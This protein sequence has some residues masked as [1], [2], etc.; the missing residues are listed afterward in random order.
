MMRPAWWRR[1]LNT[2][3]FFKG[4]SCGQCPP[5]RMGTINLAALMTKIEQGEGTQKDMESL[6]AALWIC[7]GDGLL[8]AGDRC[9]SLGAEQY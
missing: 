9:R 3:N 1:R 7:E 5:C 2:P 4:E 8:H 6:A